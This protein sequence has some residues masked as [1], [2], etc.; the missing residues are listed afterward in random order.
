MDSQGYVFLSLVANFKRVRQLTTDLELIKYVCYQSPNI[1]WRT[2][3]DGKDRLRRRDNWQQWVMPMEDREKDVQNDGPEEVTK[4]PAPV[5]QGF[6]QQMQGRHSVAGMPASAAATTAPWSTMNGTTAQYGMVSPTEP[7][8]VQQVQQAQQ[9]QA[10][11]MNGYDG[12]STYMTGG[13]GISVSSPPLEQEADAFSDA[14]AANLVIIVNKGPGIAQAGLPP[15]TTRT[16]SNS[17]LDG[18]NSD[19]T[20]IVGRQDSG[21][22][23]NG[24]ISS[25]G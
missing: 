14:E 18:R 15:A 2:A 4:P 10:M 16:F 3:A 19:E 12:S 9:A 11:M 1:E 25:R 7:Q 8:N 17:S 22:I 23:P 6:E 5:P 21:P 13:P 20:R 24:S